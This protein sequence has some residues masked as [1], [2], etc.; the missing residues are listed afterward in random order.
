V[1]A[2]EN[3]RYRRAVA[4]GDLGRGFP[5]RPARDAVGAETYVLCKINASSCFG[6]ATKR[7]R[8][9]HGRSKTASSK[10]SRRFPPIGG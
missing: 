8:R 7:R 10:P 3:A 9:S 2:M 5:L 6:N 4:A 1:E